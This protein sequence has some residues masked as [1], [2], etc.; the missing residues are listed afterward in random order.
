MYTKPVT[1]EEEDGGQ[2]AGEEEEGEAVHQHVGGVVHPGH[3]RRKQTVQISLCA[4]LTVL[5]IFPN[6]DQSLFLQMKR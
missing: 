5:L 2:E 1:Y 4:P 3:R 6:P